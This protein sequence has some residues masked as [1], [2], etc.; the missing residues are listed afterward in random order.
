MLTGRLANGIPTAKCPLTGRSVILPA[1]ALC[2]R[3]S[4]TIN[5]PA[6]GQPHQWDAATHSLSRACA[7]HGD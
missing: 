1:T 2:L 7:A 3:E 6:C 5:C 4:V